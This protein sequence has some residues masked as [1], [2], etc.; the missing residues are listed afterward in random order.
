M[1]IDN[2]RI[3]V[4]DIPYAV[5]LGGFSF[6]AGADQT[7]NGNAAG[8]GISNLCKYALGLDPLAPAANP[9]QSSRITVGA[10]TFLQLTVTRDALATQVLIEGLSAATLNDPGA[11]ST[12][13]T[14]IEDSTPTLFRVRD[15]LPIGT[16]NRRFLKLRFTL[17]P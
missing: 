1:F 6:P 11:W 14:V 5:W 17:Q 2:V 4:T 7:P 10:N 12:G 9:C 3:S 15:A 13:T 8:D 16:D